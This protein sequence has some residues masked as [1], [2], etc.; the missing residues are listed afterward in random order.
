MAASDLLSLREVLT[1]EKNALLVPP[2]DGGALAAAINRLLT[3]PSLQD[4]LVDCALR[5]SVRFG[6]PQRAKGILEFMKSRTEGNH[7]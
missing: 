2:D 1:H 5:D 4:R 7:P 6:W 3:D